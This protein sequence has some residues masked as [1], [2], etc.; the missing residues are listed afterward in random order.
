[1]LEIAG[2]IILAVA[3]FAFLPLIIAGGMVLLALGLVLLAG[4]LLF[5]YRDEVLPVLA[6]GVAIGVGFGLPLWLYQKATKWSPRFKALIDGEYPFNS[7]KKLPL[8]VAVT[9]AT[10]V[11][12]VVLGLGCVFILAELAETLL[13]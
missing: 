5:N 4:V 13:P 7:L 1:M 8:R 6:G 3:F 9:G 10:A 11:A 12:G 2:G